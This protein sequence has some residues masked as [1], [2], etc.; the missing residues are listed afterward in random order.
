VAEISAK[1]VKDLRDATGAGMMEC[2]RALSD[3]GG[4][5][6][7]AT[8]LLRERGLAKAGKREGR[9]T[10]EGSIGLAIAGRIGAL[11]DLGCETDFVAMNDKVKA[12]V[13]KLAKIVAEDSAIGT[14]EALM[15]AKVD[16]QLV[17]DVLT[18]HISTIGENMNIRRIE[19]L[20]VEGTGIVGG[21]VHGGKL[22]VLVGLKTSATGADVEE[23]AKDIAMHVAAADPT[24]LAVDRSGVPAA[25]VAKERE[26]LVKQA[27]D[28]GKPDSIIEKMVDGRINKF[29][30]DVCLLEQAFVKDPDT[31]VKARVKATSEKVG[32]GIEVVAFLRVK[33]GE[34]KSE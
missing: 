28:S 19:R 32:T 9:A 31:K 27:K 30:A 18:Q 20:E 33:V 16:G 13:A 11:V 25:V 24:P 5:P 6:E 29:Y 15:A 22:G 12:L 8:E 17:S 2:K 26:F 14:P 34:A 1:A 4:D 10:S 23:L 3:S 21:Y 7:K